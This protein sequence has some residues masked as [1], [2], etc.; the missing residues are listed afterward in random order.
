MQMSFFSEPTSAIYYFY[1][2]WS[3]TFRFLREKGVILEFIKG[4]CTREWL[5]E[6]CLNKKNVTIVI[7]DQAM[8]L[9]KEV[10]E[11]FSVQSHQDGVNCILLAQNLFTKNRFSGMPA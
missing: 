3:P 9:T 8:S 7:D 1:N 2:T 4:M 6:K 11:I 5:H 10:A